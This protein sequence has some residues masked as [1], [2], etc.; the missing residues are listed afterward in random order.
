MSGS[1]VIIAYRIPLP[2][3]V[4]RWHLIYCMAGISITPDTGLLGSDL[5]PV[6]T[7][8]VTG[9]DRLHNKAYCVLSYLRPEAS[10]YTTSD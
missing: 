5:C 3:R 7:E 4:M 1:I 6:D 2:F 8:Q 10:C 9:N